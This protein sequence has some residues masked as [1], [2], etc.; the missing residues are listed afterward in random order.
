M[1][2]C[3]PDPLAGSEAT[4]GQSSQWVQPSD[5]VPAVPGAPSRDWYVGPKGADTSAGT[6]AA[7]LRTVGRAVALAN[8]G[9]VIRVFPGVY[10]EELTLGSK[11]SGAAAITLRGEGTPRP[12]IVPGR[13]AQSAVVRVQG[14]WNLQ[15][16]H[17]D[18]GGAPMFA[19]LFSAG[20]DQSSLSDSELNAGIAG[21]GVLVEA[22]RGITLERNAIHHFIRPGDD[23]HG[24]VVVGPSRDITIRDNELHHNSGDSVQCQ[25][26]S[27]PAAGL[28]IEGNR[29]HDEGEN[30]VD[31]KNC[32]GVVIR[33][34]DMGGFPNTAIRA[35]GSSAGEAVVIHQSARDV[36][37]KDNT[38][39]R[40]GRGVSILGDGADPENIQ[41]VGNHF[42]EIRNSPAGNGQ[43]VRI[44]CARSVTVLDNVFEGTAGYGLMLAADGKTVTGLDVRNNT[45][46][47]SAKALLVRLGEERYRPGMRLRDN[48]YAVGGILKADNVAEKLGGTNGRYAPD[49]PGDLLT[50]SSASKLDVWRQVLGVDQGT[51][52]VE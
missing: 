23:S 45:L 40:A 26:G 16:L 48:R 37:V 20:G 34:N 14:R 46:K 41:V 4:G 13:K 33:G 29:M 44:E 36:T 1:L 42:Q 39:A 28:L 52:L 19:L 22:G 24:V 17:I 32:Q 15:N 10:S 50:L 8:P 31:I 30:A 11:G 35:A 9:D 18:V 47:G 25:A 7:P 2:A 12:S 49:F 5:D 6:L 38:I 27:A 43:G 3:G 51:A 21:A